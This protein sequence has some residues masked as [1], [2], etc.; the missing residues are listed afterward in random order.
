MAKKA[1]KG[2]N[3]PDAAVTLRLTLDD[4]RKITAAGDSFGGDTWQQ[5]HWGHKMTID[6][7]PIE[8]RQVK[9]I[10]KSSPANTEPATAPTKAVAKRSTKKSVKKQ[11]AE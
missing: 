10:K 4:L 9:A 1:S 6:V 7:E 2:S 5:V 11:S 8:E 3:Q